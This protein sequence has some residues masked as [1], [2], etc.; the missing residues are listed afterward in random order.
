MTIFIFMSWA[1]QLRKLNLSPPHNPGSLTRPQS[2]IIHLCK[3]TEPES[4]DLLSLFV[5]IY[6]C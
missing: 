5:E 6:K 4:P 3:V 1:I 2:S